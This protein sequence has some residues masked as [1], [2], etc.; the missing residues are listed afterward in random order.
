M[1][2]RRCGWLQPQGEPHT[3]GVAL[4]HAQD[5]GRKV[6]AVVWSDATADDVLIG[7]GSEAQAARYGLDEPIPAEA[8][9]NDYGHPLDHLR[10]LWR[11][12]RLWWPAL[13]AWAIWRWPRVGDWLIERQIR[14]THRVDRVDP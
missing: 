4:C 9:V 13:W 2:S 10:G 3:V 14:R 7:D 11:R 12:P 1:E 6:W 5:D 8:M